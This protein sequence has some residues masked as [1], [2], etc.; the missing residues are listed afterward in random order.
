MNI[1][2]GRSLP[3]IARHVLLGL[4]SGVVVMGFLQFLHS[5]QLVYQISMATAYG[6][7]FLFALSLTIGPW[8]V[9]RHRANP[10]S[11][12]LRRD[13]GIWAGALAL[14]HVIAGIQVHMAGKFWL[15]FIP[16]P[17]EHA[18][19][20][21]RFDVFGLTNYAGL[22]ATVLLVM[23]LCLSNDA[24][25]RMLGGRR[26]KTLQRWNYAAAGLVFMHG[27]VY[28]II[29]KRNPSFV[30]VFTIV[31]LVVL[32]FQLAGFRHVRRMKKF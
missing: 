23:L 2:S 24:S 13:I 31:V 18:V 11:S 28:Q 10:P 30:L 21:V 1:K 4:A 29:E 27:W 25:V 12:Y 32:A 9:L 17:D 3:R 16:S 20:P 6:S 8:N 19:L 7:L 14:V 15:Y 5:P 26:W 22:V